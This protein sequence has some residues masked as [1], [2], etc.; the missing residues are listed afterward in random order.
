MTA[1]SICIIIPF[2]NQRKILTAISS[3]EFVQ[4]TYKQ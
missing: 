3:A 1:Q 4:V 2:Q